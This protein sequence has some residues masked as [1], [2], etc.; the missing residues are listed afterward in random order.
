MAGLSV[1]WVSSG[2]EVETGELDL[3]ARPPTYRITGRVNVLL[4]VIVADPCIELMLQKKA[5]FIITDETFS[6]NE[7]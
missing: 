5:F 2:S 1:D 6:V 3:E 7:I 4:N